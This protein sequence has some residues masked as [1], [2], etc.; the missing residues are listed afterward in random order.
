MTDAQT[1]CDGAIV[2]RL[3]TELQTN[4]GAELEM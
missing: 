3:E 4:L 2:Y 1:N